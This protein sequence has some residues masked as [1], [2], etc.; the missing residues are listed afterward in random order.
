MLWCMHMYEYRGRRGC[1]GTLYHSVSPK[2]LL[3]PV[4]PSD[5]LLSGPPH[6]AGVSGTT[7]YMSSW[8][9]NSGPH[10]C[11]ASSLTDWTI[12]PAPEIALISTILLIMIWQH[13]VFAGKVVDEKQTKCVRIFSLA[14]KNSNTAGW[15]LWCVAVSAQGL[16]KPSSGFLL[17]SCVN[18][19]S[20][21]F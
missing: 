18:M 10:A 4:S 16:L 19:G 1:L 9:L 20:W 3:G 8:D 12:S 14:Q 17:I 5:P 7:L 2:L 13:T 15:R 21:R 11:L 6:S